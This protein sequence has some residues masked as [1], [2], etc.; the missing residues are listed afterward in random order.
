MKSPYDAKWSL[1]NRL[2]KKDPGTR[3]F[4]ELYDTIYD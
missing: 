2:E 4:A 3:Y 1:I